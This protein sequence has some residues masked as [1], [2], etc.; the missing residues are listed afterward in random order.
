MA[1]VSPKRNRPGQA[2]AVQLIVG[3]QRYSRLPKIDNSQMN[4]V[5]KLP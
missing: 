5:T 1:R 2:R 3:L 4:I